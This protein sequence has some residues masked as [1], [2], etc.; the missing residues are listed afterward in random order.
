MPST[1]AAVFL[2]VSAV[3]F[4]ADPAAIWSVGIDVIPAAFLFAVTWVSVFWL[5]GLYRLRARW[6]W[7]AEARDIVRGTVVVLA[8]TLSLLF[9]LH[10]DDVSRLFLA[11]LFVA[12]PAV[13]LAGRAVLRGWFESRRRRGR[14]TNYM[15]IVGT[16]PLAQAFAD[17]I[18]SHAALGIKVVG[19]LEAGALMPDASS[20]SRPVLGTIDEINAVFRTHVIDEVGDL[21]CRG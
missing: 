7:L 8:L 9:L 2:L 14:D 19:H 10:Q 17:R 18:E 1:A 12:Q 11:L 20:V 5:L 13:M 6:G 21:P 4:E 15:L 3:R 16:G